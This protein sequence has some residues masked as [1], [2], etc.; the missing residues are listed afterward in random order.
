MRFLAGVKT[1]AILDFQSGTHS[2]ILAFKTRCFIGWFFLSQP[3]QMRHLHLSAMP[4]LTY[5]IRNLYPYSTDCRVAA[6]VLTQQAAGNLTRVLLNFYPDR[7][8]IRTH[9]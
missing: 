5:K 4:C 3:R 2:F 6:F 1:I 8:V 9:Y 7:A